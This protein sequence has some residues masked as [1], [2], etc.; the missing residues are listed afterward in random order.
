MAVEH[1]RHWAS[2]LTAWLNTLGRVAAAGT[3]MVRAAELLAVR[4]PEVSRRYRRDM[5][6]H[7]RV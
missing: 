4:S 5:R 3:I 1:D 2:I 6:R 7:W